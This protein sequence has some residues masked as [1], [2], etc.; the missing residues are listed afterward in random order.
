VSASRGRRPGV[1][2]ASSD[3][4]LSRMMAARQRDTAPEIELRAELSRL[5]MR[6]RLHRAVVPG[7]RRRPDIVFGSARMAVFVDGCFWH[8]CPRHGTMAKSNRRFW[9]GKILANK[10]RDTD[11]NRR[12]RAAGWRVVR[13]WEHEDP[14]RAAAR[15]ARVLHGDRRL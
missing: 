15:I 14:R 3:A 6:Y 7:V 5:G 10:V 13:V 8:G 1:P 2:P 4:A 9:E 11:T 12:L